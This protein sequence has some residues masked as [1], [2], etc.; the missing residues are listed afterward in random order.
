MSTLVRFK[1]VQLEQGRQGSGQAGD[2]VGERW[3]GQSGGQHG[4]AP[5]V[6][7]AAPLR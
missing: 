1:L 4:G 5:V 6:T 3:N 7:Y 2:A